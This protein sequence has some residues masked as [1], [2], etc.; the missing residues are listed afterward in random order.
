MIVV[1][2]IGGLG[3]QMFQYAFAYR[4]AKLSGT[5]LKMDIAGFEKYKLHKV[6]IHHLNVNYK[7]S[8]ID[9]QRVNKLI[10]AYGP[11]R[12]L[13]KYGVLKPGIKIIKDKEQGFQEELISNYKEDI[14]LDGFWQSEKYFKPVESEI[15]DHLRV[16]TPPSPANESILSK[17]KNSNA[18]SVHIRRADYVTNPATLAFHGICSMDYYKQ[19]TDIIKSKTPNPRFFI[20]SDDIEWAKQNIHFN[21]EQFFAD[22]NNA[23]TNYEDLRLMYSC[24]HHVIAN[25]SFSWWGAWMNPLGEKIVIA[26]GKW[27]N[28]PEFNNPDI[29]PG[30]WIRI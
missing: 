23:D 14:Y 15:R 9:R 22:I 28:N 16:I 8:V 3:N 19:A 12:W 2:L 13:K 26:P 10:H 1:K 6:A 29:I 21:A 30:S 7:Q 18:V 11:A 24:R 27:Y 20:F 17:I 25:S 5:D 4:L